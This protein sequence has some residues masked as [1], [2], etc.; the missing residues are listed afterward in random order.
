MEEGILNFVET[1][2]KRYVICVSNVIFFLSMLRKKE[3]NFTEASRPHF[4][5]LVHYC[6]GLLRRRSL[7]YFQQC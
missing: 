1:I 4:K 5:F 6:V 7:K 3:F 2:L